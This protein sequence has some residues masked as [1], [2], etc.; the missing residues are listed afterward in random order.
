[1][2]IKVT[3]EFLSKFWAENMYN[4][5]N[6]QGAYYIFRLNLG[7]VCDLILHDSE[8]THFTDLP[9]SSPLSTITSALRT[10]WIQRSG[11][12]W[13]LVNFDH[14]VRFAYGLNKKMGTWAERKM[15]GQTTQP[16]Y[17][18]W[19]LRSLCVRFEYK[20]GH[21]SGTQNERSSNPTNGGATFYVRNVALE[22][23]KKWSQA[24]QKP[25]IR[26]DWRFSV[27]LTSFCIP[28]K[29]LHL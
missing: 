28:L 22:R 12:F 26:T 13:E 23:N 21:L 2:K 7:L 11:N 20:S 10:L 25:S 15:N 19:P 3:T 5:N 14:C 8:K 18:C 6:I 9:A 17:I 29:C 16:V 4:V 24:N 27:C 1:M